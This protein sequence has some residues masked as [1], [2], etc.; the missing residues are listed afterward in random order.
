M[1]YVVFLLSLSSMFYIREVC[2]LDPPSYLQSNRVFRKRV[3]TRLLHFG[4]NQ[5]TIISLLLKPS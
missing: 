4:R 3:L 2:V 1:Y 5:L